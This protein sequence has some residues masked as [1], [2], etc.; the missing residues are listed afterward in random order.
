MVCKN[1]LNPLLSKRR[2]WGDFEKN[3]YFCSVRC[4][5]VVFFPCAFSICRWYDF[6]S[7]FVFV[8]PI[9]NLTKTMTASKDGLFSIVGVGSFPFA[10]TELSDLW[11]AIVCNYQVVQIRVK[12]NKSHSF[13]V[14]RFARS[15]PVPISELG[16]PFVG[17]ARAQQLWS[18]RN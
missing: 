6:P 10:S 11:L 13:F 17:A 8:F 18:R 4:V 2:D 15:F 14:S 5:H 12:D 16:I 3:C 7:Q 1:P 9:V